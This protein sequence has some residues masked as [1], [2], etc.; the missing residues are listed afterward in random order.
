MKAGSEEMRTRLPRSD[1]VLNIYTKFAC[2]AGD[3]VTYYNS[4]R[5]MNGHVGIGVV[6]TCFH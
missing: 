2:I 1:F 5:L 3:K 4:R 6:E